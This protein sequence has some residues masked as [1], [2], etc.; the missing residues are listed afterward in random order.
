[1]PKW[2]IVDKNCQLCHQA[3]GTLEHRRICPCVRPEQGWA[4]VPEEAKLAAEAVGE[5]RLRL[6]RNTGLLAIKLPAKHA[7]MHETLSWGKR[8]EQSDR[9]D[10]TWYIDGSQ[11]MPRRRDLSTLGFG[12]VAVGSDGEL[13][14]WGWGAPPNWCDSA[15][16][17]EAW[18][19][20]TVL[21]VCGP[22]D[23][24]VT[25]CLGLLKTAEK[26]AAAATTAKKCL[27]RTWN[28]IAHHVDGRLETLRESRKL[29]WMP[30]H[31]PPAAIGNALKSTGAPITA[32][33]WRANHLV[34]GLA[35]LAAT[36]GATTKQEAKLV[37][38]AEHLVRHC[39]GQLAAATYAANN[40]KEK[41]T[42]ADGREK[43]RTRRD[44]QEFPRLSTRQLKPLAED[45]KSKPVAAEQA[46][47]SASEPSDL[48]RPLTEP[49][50]RRRVRHQA[51]KKE[52]ERQQQACDGLVQQQRRNPREAAVDSYRRQQEWQALQRQA[53]EVP[54]TGEPQP[55]PL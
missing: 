24:I 33:D 6:L 48:E 52:L 13:L 27:A 31:R 43:T 12:L 46:H 17:A 14:A 23:R 30:A 40:F 53:L 36:E 1:M 49:Q 50:R 21:Q 22:D 32:L 39:A 7:R 19:L 5:E 47:D 41:F 26:G 37:E 34:D 42:D 4:P 2:G 11:L 45:K 18:A 35:K 20:C 25:D 16:A 15:S 3:P 29:T 38:S 54:G 9:T 51:R 10:V 28:L 55:D 44:S 8:L